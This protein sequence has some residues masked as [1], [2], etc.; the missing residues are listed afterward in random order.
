MIGDLT[1]RIV[2]FRDEREWEQFHNAKNLATSIVIESAE[3]LELLQ[4]SSDATLDADVA[5]KLP[6]IKRELADIAIYTLLMAH[7]LA[8]DIEAA[9]GDKLAENEAKYPA[10]KARGRNTKYTDL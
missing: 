6:D 8:I 4:W 5:S 2:D 9:I 1:A 7:D 10:E 3:L